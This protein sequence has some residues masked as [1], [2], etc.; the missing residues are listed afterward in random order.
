MSLTACKE[1]KKE[2]SSSAKNCPHCGISNPGLKKT[3]VVAGLVVLATLIGGIA[4]GCAPDKEKMAAESAVATAK[5]TKD[6]ADTKALAAALDAKCMADLQ[7]WGDKHIASASI[8]C[9]REIEK[10]AHYSVKWTDTM[11]EMKF[12]RFAWFDKPNGAITFVG[13]KIQFQN[14]FGAYQDSIYECDFQPDGHVV[15]G[16]RAEPGRL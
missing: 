9:K 2:V 16:A 4:Y 14:G 6:D 10:L 7:C 15:L 11:L 1:C 8:Y 3:E 13:D 5:K 12:S